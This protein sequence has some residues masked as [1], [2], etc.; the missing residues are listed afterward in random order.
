MNRILSIIIPVFNEEGSI[1]LLIDRINENINKLIKKEIIS[2]HE[3]IFISDGSTD[4]SEKIIKEELSKDNHIKLIV[5]RANFS[6]LKP[7]F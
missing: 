4:N 2:E 3:I 7:C 1:K 5:F 6:K